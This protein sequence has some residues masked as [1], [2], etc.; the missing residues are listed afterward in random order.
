[1]AYISTGF[2]VLTLIT[3]STATRISIIASMLNYILFF[4]KD[5]IQG[6]HRKVVSASRRQTYVRQMKAAKSEKDSFHRCEV[7]QRTEKDDPN[8]EFRYCSKCDG[9]HEYCSDH[10]FS[11]EHIKENIK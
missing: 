11:H 10:L 3:G 2:L 4:G 9:Y 8:L 1:M 6:R 5:L 7:C